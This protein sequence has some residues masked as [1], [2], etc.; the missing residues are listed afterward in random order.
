[1]S[2]KSIPVEK[3]IEA[4]SKVVSGEKIQPVAKEIGV[5]RSSIY[6]WKERALS[7][8]EEALEPHKRGPKF[9][10][11]QKT[12]EKIMEGL[13]G[14]INRLRDC[15]EEK[16]RQI[17]LLKHR[18]E[19]QKDNS[20][21]ARCPNCGC[22]KVYRNGTYK[23]KPKGFFDNLKAR[24]E[25]L[26]QFF[27]CTYCGKSFHIKKQNFPQAHIRDEIR[28]VIGILRTDGK[29]SLRALEACQA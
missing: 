4:V 8:L 7:A 28:R 11:P 17:Y 23:V 14:E 12:P 2:F 29:I 15:L 16:E 6:I 9:K 27:I 1:M 19:P 5:H 25:E 13:K 20:K 3:K 26:I 24:K 18:L 21:P 10:H 22:E